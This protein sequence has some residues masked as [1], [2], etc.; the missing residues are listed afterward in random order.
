[1]KCSEYL[2]KRLEMDKEMPED[3]QPWEVQAKVRSMLGKDDIV[4]DTTGKVM[5]E[6]DANSVLGRSQKALLARF[7]AGDREGFD[8][9]VI[10]QLKADDEYEAK[11]GKQ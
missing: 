4:S 8:A 1:M 10:D 5:L 9:R 3:V 11:K 6:R 2:W 7:N